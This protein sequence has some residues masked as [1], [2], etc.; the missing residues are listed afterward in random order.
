MRLTRY[1]VL[2]PLSIHGRIAATGE[3]V[4]LPEY[5]AVE[6]IETGHLLEVEIVN[7]EASR[8]WTQPQVRE[9]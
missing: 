2:T 4:R 1:R 9:A 6:W 7:G 5:V 8:Q 3:L